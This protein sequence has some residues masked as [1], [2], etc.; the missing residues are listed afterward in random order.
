MFNFYQGLMSIA[1]ATYTCMYLYTVKTSTIISTLF[2]VF[3]CY[4]TSYTRPVIQ[5]QLFKTSY[6][7]FI[8]SNTCTTLHYIYIIYLYIT[9]TC[10]CT[11]AYITYITY[12]C[13]HYTTVLH[14]HVQ[15]I[16]YSF[17]CTYYK[18]CRTHRLRYTCIIFTH[19]FPRKRSQ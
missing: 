18:Q 11:C 1:T 9:D 6:F 7:H 2:I 3:N 12:K 19:V 8:N 14:V 10:T 5:D 4:K 16:H 15:C 13:I 17:T